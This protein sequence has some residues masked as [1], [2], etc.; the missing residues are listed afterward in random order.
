MASIVKLDNKWRALIRR[1]GHKPISK[2]FDT[3][4]KAQVWAADIERQIASGAMPQ[5]VTSG[6]TISKIIEKYRKL[7]ATTRP[8]LDTSSEHYT[9][10]MLDRMLGDKSDLTP[11]DIVAW[12]MARRDEGAKEYTVNCDLSK[13]GTVFRYTVGP[14]LAIQSARPKLAYL[15]L[16][17]GGGLRER[18]PTE[19]EFSLL[20]Q[21]L[22]EEKSQRYADYARFAALTAMR[23][24]EVS[25]ILWSDVDYEKKMVLIRNRKDPRRKLGNDQWIPLLS[26]SWELMLSQPKDNDRIFP[27][28]I[29]TVS[30]Y[31]KESCD[32]L[33]IPDLHFHDLRHSGITKLFEQGLGIQHV[34]L[35]SG[36]KSW[37][38]LKRYTNLKP[39]S[40]HSLLPSLSSQDTRQPQQSQPNVSRHP[41]KS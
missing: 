23:R 15:K 11:D 40:L 9:L 38:H 19:E 33:G 41:D 28:H 13:L 35:V 30:R 4:G 39:E 34:A 29:Q 25:G 20:L 24:G 1:K 18:L 2:F 37:D 26:G 14:C 17:G 22:T 31:F 32:A 36:H 16:I 10:K 7:R 5:S 21:W 8:I 27:L 3:K 12:A 6:E